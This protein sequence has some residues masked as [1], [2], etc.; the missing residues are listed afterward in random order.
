MQCAICCELRRVDSGPGVNKAGP[1]A[2]V[3][4]CGVAVGEAAG[5]QL[6]AYLA[7]RCV[8][9]VGTVSGRPPHCPSRTV[10]GRPVAG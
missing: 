8:V 5:V 10:V 7:D 9:N 1:E 3:I 6:G 2:A 4:V